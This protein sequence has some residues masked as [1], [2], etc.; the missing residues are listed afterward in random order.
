M[1]SSLLRRSGVSLFASRITSLLISALT[2]VVT[3]RL[4][5]PD[6]FGVFAAGASVVVVAWALGSFGL[7]QLLM[8]GQIDE[9][10]FRRGVISAA[11]LVFVISSI[12]VAVWPNLSATS[13][14]V[15]LI[16]SLAAATTVLRLPWTLVPGAHLQFG[17]RAKRELALACGVSIATLS[18][19]A[20]LRSPLAAAAGAASV[21]L[22][23]VLLV[24]R[25]KG[26]G[27]ATR[28]AKPMASRDLLR[29]GLPFALSGVLYA[30]YFALDASIL[31]ALRPAAEVGF[32]RVAYSFVM[33]AVAIAVVINN[34]I[35]RPILARLGVTF[36]TARPFLLIS[37]SLG[38]LVAGAFYGLAPFLVKVVYGSGFSPA[39]TPLRILG[40]ALLPHFFN[41][42]LVNIYISHGRLRRVLTVQGVLLV[43]NIGLNLWLIPARGGEGAAIATLATE[44]LG[45]A[46][47][48]YRLKV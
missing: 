46:L 15:G 10:D 14:G 17:V 20:V 29:K 24:D 28:V 38:V 5:G 3:A 40:L 44:A 36:A 33:V 45:V 12:A 35:M 27:M 47:Y 4:L 26:F 19:T 42:W 37:A 41:A 31:A 22:A 13:R 43:V 23:I 21:G 25:G 8:A 9:S 18:L 11:V 1:Q 32:Y 39:V 16:V 48:G 7:D 2:G 34:D 30:L 6:K